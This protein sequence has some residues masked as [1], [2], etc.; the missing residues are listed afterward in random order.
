M[1][2]IFISIVVG[3]F[4]LVRRELDHMATFFHMAV[5]HAKQIGFQGQFLIEPKP[6][7]PTKHQCTIQR[8]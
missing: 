4:C 6:K 2:F 7:E 8:Y 5:A 1:D 3:F